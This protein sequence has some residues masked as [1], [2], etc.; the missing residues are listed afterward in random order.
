MAEQPKRRTL[1]TEN[2]DFYVKKMDR[3][4]ERMGCKLIDWNCDRHGGYVQF[5]YKG[6]V[7]QFSHSVENAQRHGLN[8]KYGSDAFAQIILSLEDLARMVE[9]GIYDLSVWVEGMRMLPEGQRL[10]EWC[11][12]LHLSTVPTDPKVVRDAYRKLVKVLHPDAPG[13]D[14]EKFQALTNACRTALAAL[15]ADSQA[16]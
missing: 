7:Y 14:A 12:A 1:Y 11:V 4:M 6:Q 13:G 2:T 3:V 15:G 5:Q 16:S 10:P 8:L 9:R